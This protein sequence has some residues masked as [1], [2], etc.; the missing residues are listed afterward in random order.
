MSRVYLA[1]GDGGTGKTSFALSGLRPVDYYE[2]D[3]GSFDRAKD[4]LSNIDGI[5]VKKYYAPLTNI[6]GQGKINVSERGGMAPS[7]VHRLSGWK[8]LFW[9]FVEDYLEDLNGDGYPVFD[10]ET[11]L[12]LIIR[13]GFLQEAQDAVGPDKDRLDQ[14]QYTEANARHGQIVEAA[15]AKGKDLVMLAHEKELYKGKEA[16]GQMVPDGYK[17]IPNMADCTLRFQLKNKKPV[18]TIMKAGSGG[19][20][21][22]GMEI[23]EPTLPKMNALLDAASKIRRS[24]M[25]VP[26][27]YEKLM[28]TAEALG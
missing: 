28:E 26:S 1:Y 19:L 24:S 5:R 16:T 2:T 17:E 13:Q 6:L 3:P 8:E 14:L 23:E 12:W 4:G 27:S 20:E 10:T 7:T 15:Q 18:A 9:K 25:N 22:L 11:R 21:L